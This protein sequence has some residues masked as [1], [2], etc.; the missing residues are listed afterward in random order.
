MTDPIKVLTQEN[1]LSNNVAPTGQKYKIVQVEGTTLFAISRDAGDVGPLPAEL[2]GTFTSGPK[3]QVQ[4]TRFLLKF[5]KQSD[6]S[7]RVKKV[8]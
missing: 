7:K 8:A 3:A 4:L 5:W 6:D 2:C 1:S